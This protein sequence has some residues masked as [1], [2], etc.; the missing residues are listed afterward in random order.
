MIRAPQKR[1]AWPWKLRALIRDCEKRLGQTCGR[2]WQYRR[3]D[4]K[5]VV[6]GS[7]AR[8]TRLIAV[9]DE[10]IL[11]EK[12]II[13]SICEVCGSHNEPTTGCTCCGG[14]VAEITAP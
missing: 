5:F 2:V 13:G 14:A 9:V 7:F 4:G 8:I 10:P 3:D 12:E 1:R 11:K 6:K